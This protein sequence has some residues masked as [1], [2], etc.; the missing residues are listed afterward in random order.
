VHRIEIGAGDRRAFLLFIERWWEKNC[1]ATSSKRFWLSVIFLTLCFAL[2]LAKLFFYQVIDPPLHFEY[3]YS[4]ENFL[5]PQMAVGFY[6]LS[7]IMLS[8]SFYYLL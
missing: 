2:L 4:F 6:Q 5:L 1:M 7:D 3:E 8:N